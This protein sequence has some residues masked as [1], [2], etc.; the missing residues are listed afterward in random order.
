MNEV[1]KQ[2]NIQF[3]AL[4]SD[5]SES[6][7][8]FYAASSSST[9]RSKALSILLRSTFAEDLTRNGQKCYASTVVTINEAPL[10]R[11]LAY[12]AH[13]PVFRNHLMVLD[14]SKEIARPQGCSGGI[15]L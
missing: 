7:N 10:L 14:V 15:C 12:K 4:L 1:N 9:F 13:A 2:G 5:S 3:N 8:L 6:K 11:D